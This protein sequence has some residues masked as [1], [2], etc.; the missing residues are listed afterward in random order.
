ML[1]VT[2]FEDNH[3]LA[4]D[5]TGKTIQVTRQITRSA[6][7]FSNILIHAPRKACRIFT[8]RIPQWLKLQGALHHNNPISALR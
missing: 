6:P 1:E 5:L 3:E 2:E 4:R 7:A 8:R